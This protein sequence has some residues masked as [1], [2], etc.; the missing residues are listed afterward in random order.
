MKAT[1]YFIDLTKEQADELN[2]TGWD[3]PIGKAYLAAKDGRIDATNF[4]LLQ[5]AATFEFVDGAERIWLSLQNHDEPWT[6]LPCITCHTE[7][8][9]SMDVGDIIVWADGTRERCASTGFDRV[10]GVWED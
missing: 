6:T 5:K 2:A 10:H 3:S 9:R 7:R 8:P 4:D 1:V